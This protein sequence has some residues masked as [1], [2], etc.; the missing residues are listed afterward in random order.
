MEKAN[1]FLQYCKY[2][3]GED[4]NP[5][6]FGVPAHNFWILE[7]AHINRCIIGDNDI[8]FTDDVKGSFKEAWEYIKT[9][10]DKFVREMLCEFVV[11]HYSH[12]PQ[13][14]IDFIFEYGK[15]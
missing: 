3:K 15:V 7:A 2:Y 6:P 8:N 5:F 1:D 10:D 13:S 4:E 14:G 11:M 9:F 12:N